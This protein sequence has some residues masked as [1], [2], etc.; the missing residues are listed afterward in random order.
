MLEIVLK[1]FNLFKFLIKCEKNFKIKNQIQ[2]QERKETPI[3][4]IYGILYLL[5]S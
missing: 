1:L 5:V 3:T 2:F 4:L